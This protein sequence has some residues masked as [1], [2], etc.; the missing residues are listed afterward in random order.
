MHLIHQGALP[1]QI[2]CVTFTKKAAGELKERLGLLVGPEVAKAV[3]FGTFH[4]LAALLLRQ[5]IHLLPQ[6]RQNRKFSIYDTDDSQ[7]V[8][9]GVL[10]AA[11]EADGQKF[12][13]DDA[14]KYCKLFSEVKNAVS[15]SYQ[16]SATAALRVLKERGHKFVEGEERY[17][18]RIWDA[19]E[20][21][22]AASNALDFDDL[23]SW[24][25]ALLRDSK[26][27]AR[28][29]A[30]RWPFVLVDEF[31]DS[32][33]AQ[34]ELINLLAATPG[35]ERWLPNARSLL[36]VGDSDQSI[37]GWRGAQEALLRTRLGADL[38]HSALHLSLTSNYR[39]TPQILSAADALLDEMVSRS[40][41]RV[42]PVLESGAPVEL[43]DHA[44]C[45]SEPPAVADEIQ[46]LMNGAQCHT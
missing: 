9:R 11:L 32:N 46:K 41:L 24:A 30:E 35:R 21:A 18:P 20:Q 2:V 33:F 29:L 7:S 22:L 43:W 3:T 4:S 37:Y 45:S 40:E 39:S 5:H 26:H 1:S 36:V 6:V 10:V 17:F 19:Y 38:G 31:Q 34:Y 13:K 27:L 44:S 28:R 12:E 42:R 23:V 25:V 14:T 16:L 15:C 8:V